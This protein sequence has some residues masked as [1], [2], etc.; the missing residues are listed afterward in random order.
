MNLNCIPGY[1]PIHT[2]LASS[3]QPTPAQ[4]E[5]IA[6]A[7][8]QVIINLAMPDSDRAF[9]WQANWVHELGMTQVQIPVPYDQPQYVHLHGFTALMQVHEERAVW[10][11]CALNWRASAFLYLDARIRLH[12]GRKQAAKRMLPGWQPDRLWQAFIEAHDPA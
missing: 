7:G 2:G 9:P 6:R 8:F 11:H 12:L 1:H 4:F 5:T 3:G 10:V